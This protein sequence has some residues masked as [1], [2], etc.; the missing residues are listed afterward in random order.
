MR[1]WRFPGIVVLGLVALQAVPIRAGAGAADSAGA[2]ISPA[3]VQS[4]TASPPPP[5]AADDTKILFTR[6]DQNNTLSVWVADADGANQQKL[7]D[8]R[9]EAT[10]GPGGGQLAMGVQPAF[11]E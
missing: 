1:A 7:Y 2:P 10:W 8:G 3:R 6:A 11:G 5:P 9:S 4:A